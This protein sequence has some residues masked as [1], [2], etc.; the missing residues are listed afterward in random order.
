MSWLTVCGEIQVASG[1]S[2]PIEAA[3]KAA[4]LILKMKEAFEDWICVSGHLSSYYLPLLPSTSASCDL[5]EPSGLIIRVSLSPSPSFARRPMT[6]LKFSSE[7]LPVW[8][9]FKASKC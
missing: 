9:V 2:V 1:I 8:L 7:G 5:R 6:N 3:R 4:V